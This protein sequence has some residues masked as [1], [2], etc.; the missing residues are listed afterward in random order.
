MEPPSEQRMSGGHTKQRQC[1]QGK[2]VSFSKWFTC[3]T[4]TVPGAAAHTQGVEGDTVPGGVKEMQRCGTEG[5]RL[6]GNTAR[7][8]MIGLDDLRDL[9]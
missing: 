4:G 7:R 2:E 8:R 3:P 1:H 5:H 6:M 9:F